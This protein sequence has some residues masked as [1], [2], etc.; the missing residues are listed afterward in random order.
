MLHHYRDIISRIDDDPSW[1]DEAGVPRYC[2]FEPRACANIYA[3][4]VALVE[5]ACQACG[6]R[7]K[8]SFSRNAVT[9]ILDGSYLAELIERKELHYGDP[10]NVGCCP[11]GPTMNSIP[12]R[13]LEYHHATNAGRWKRDQEY[14]V[15]LDGDAGSTGLADR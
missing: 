8:V 1:F 9:R 7:F 15:E 13:V 4:E 10:P 6:K 5:I 11:A 12:L 14:E 2:E 3:R